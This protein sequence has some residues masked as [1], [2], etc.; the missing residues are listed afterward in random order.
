[1]TGN[2]SVNVREL[3]EKI[4]RLGP[5]R[6]DVEIAP[7][8][9]TGDPAPEGVYAP[10]LG[11]PVITDPGPHMAKLTR[12][13]YAD[14]LA[15]RTV[16]DC[17]CNAGGSLFAAAGLGAGRCFGFDAREHW[18]KQARFLAEYLPSDNIEFATLDLASLREHRIGQFDITLFR[19]LFYHLPDPVNGLRIAA[20]HTKELLVVDTAT[21]PSGGGDALV[22]RC[23]SKE[24]LMSGIDGIGWLPTGEG[25]LRAILKWCGFPHVRLRWERAGGVRNWR[26]IEVVAAREAGTLAHFDAMRRDS[27]RRHPE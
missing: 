5:W 14:G 17:G 19:G 3:R 16:L 25:V 20:D 21:L 15:Q 23:E 13:I 10:E 1:M 24:P 11:T 22:L 6:H 9:R 8:V 12:E 2:H 27:D 4:I 26:R 18:I 7:G